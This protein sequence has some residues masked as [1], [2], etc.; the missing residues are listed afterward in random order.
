MHARLAHSLP[1]SPRIATYVPEHGTGV[2]SS[3]LSP[4]PPFS[5]LERIL[6]DRVGLQAQVLEETVQGLA[7]NKLFVFVERNEIFV[8][9]LECEYSLALTLTDTGVACADAHVAKI[10]PNIFLVRDERLAPSVVT[11]AISLKRL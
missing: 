8:H 3:P 11:F 1:A 4:S 7:A 10:G 9:G 6:K 2:R 5:P